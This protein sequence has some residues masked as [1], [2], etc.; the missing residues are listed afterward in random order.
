MLWLGIQIGEPAVEAVRL[1]GNYLL[2]LS[3]AVLVGTVVVAYRR[4]QHTR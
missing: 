2:W 1:Y 4:Q 3:G